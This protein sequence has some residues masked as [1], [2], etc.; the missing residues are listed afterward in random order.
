M[1]GISIYELE[2]D[3]G[4]GRGLIEAQSRY[5]SW[6]GWD[7]ITTSL[8]HNSQGTGRHSKQ[9]L[10]E[11]KSKALTLHQPLQGRVRFKVLTAGLIKIAVFYL[12]PCRRCEKC[13]VSI[14]RLKQLTLLGSTGRWMHYAPPKLNYLPVYTA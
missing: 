1:M 13:S 9:V 2:K 4:S 8:S 10:L 11:Y 14:C 5:L 12:T 6:K 7:E 3:F